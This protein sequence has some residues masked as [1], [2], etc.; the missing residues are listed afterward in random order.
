MA[1]QVPIPAAAPNHA[2]SLCQ[3]SCET[4]KRLRFQPWL[5]TESL[6]AAPVGDVAWDSAV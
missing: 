3:W 4:A 6:G 2:M 5:L 1:P